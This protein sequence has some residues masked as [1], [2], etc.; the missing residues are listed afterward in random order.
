MV[1][2]NDALVP[3]GLAFD[4]VL[5]RVPCFGEQANDFEE[6]PFCVFLMRIRQKVDHLSNRE[7]VGCH[8]TSQPRCDT[9]PERRCCTLYRPTAL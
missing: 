3:V 7:L 8:R 9:A 2:P 4:T 6:L 1:F 5:E